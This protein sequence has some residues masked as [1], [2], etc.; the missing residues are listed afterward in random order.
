MLKLKRFSYDM[1]HVSLEVQ[2]MQEKHF[3]K[4]YE[5]QL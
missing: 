1:Q 3:L 2:R 5:A 4:A